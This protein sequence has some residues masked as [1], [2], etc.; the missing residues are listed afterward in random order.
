MRRLDTQELRGPW[1]IF[2][3]VFLLASYVHKRFHSGCVA[4]SLKKDKIKAKALLNPI[5]VSYPLEVVAL[6]FRSLGRPMDAY[7]N[8]LVMTD[9][10]TRYAWAVLTRDQTAKTTVRAI[11][12]HVIQT[13][14]CP[15]SFHSDMGPNFESTLMQQLCTMYGVTKSRTTP[16]HPVGN[17]RVERL[18]QTVLNLSRTLRGEKQNRWAEHVPELLQ[19]YNNTVHSSTGF[20]PAYLMFG[21]HLRLPVDV[22]LGVTPHQPK[23]VLGLVGLLLFDDG[24]PPTH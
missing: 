13:F 1:L 4:C 14:G 8:I 21:R 2:D 24:L 23:L 20:A 17:G 3:A 6:D 9:M 16:Y 19:A 5:V 22:E 7:Q 11:W 18:N 12:S 15:G 10:F